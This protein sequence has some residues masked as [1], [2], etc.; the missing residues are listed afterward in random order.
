MFAP[1]RT[2]ERCR[3]EKEGREPWPLARPRARR[4]QVALLPIPSPAARDSGFD[5]A[6]QEVDVR[7]T[8]STPMFREVMVKCVVQ[9]RG[10]S[11]SRGIRRSWS[12]HDRATTDPRIL[13]T[14]PIPVPLARGRF[15]LSAEGAAWFASAVP[16]RCEI[17]WDRTIP[18][19]ANPSDDYGEFTYPKL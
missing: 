9:N 4:S 7:Q 6:V 8:A 1:R 16:Y 5:L 18:G 17:Q 13:K 2:R 14:A 19:D 15:V 10:P 11:L 3:P 12:S